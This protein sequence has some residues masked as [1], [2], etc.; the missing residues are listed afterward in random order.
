V[1]VCQPASGCH[2]NGDL[3]REDTDCCGG[4]PTNGLPGAGNVECQK[5][6]GA[7]LGICRNPMSCSPQGNVCHYK[8]YTCGGSSSRNNCCAGVG[9]SGVCQLDGL[10]VP[11]CNG[12]GTDCRDPGET[13]ASA[14]DCCNGVPCVPDANGILH[15]GSTSCRQTGN[16]CTINADCC[17][18]NLCIRP[19]GST[20]GT[21]G[22][23]TPPGTGGAPGSGGTAG[24]GGASGTGA[25]TGSG[26]TLG[27]GGASSTGATTGSG[28]T[29]GTGGATGTG[30]TPPVLCAE[31]G[32]QCG[33]VACCNTNLGVACIGGICKIQL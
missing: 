28:G 9:N 10:G 17:T 27:T 4:D 12:L 14:D 15:C 33:A 1:F 26:G 8:D 30:G 32:Q 20:Q 21:C 7:A 25:T 23:V 19:V 11:R 5:E 18:G 31:Y 22:A 16:S 13:C 6:S 24:T 29:T 2:V 3:C